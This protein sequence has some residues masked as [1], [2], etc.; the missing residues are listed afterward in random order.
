M[1]EP[2]NSFQPV[3]AAER[4]STSATCSDASR[5]CACHAT[6]A[7]PETIGAAK[8]VPSPYP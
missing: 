6:A 4:T 2:V 3:P 5:G 7:S 1:P 8:L